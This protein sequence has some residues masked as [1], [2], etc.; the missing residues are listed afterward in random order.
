MGAERAV[1]LKVEKQ[2][3]GNDMAVVAYVENKQQDF[4]K[5]TMAYTN[6]RNP[7]QLRCGVLLALLA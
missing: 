7:Y 3:L 4:Q 1:L 5:I 2:N 6:L